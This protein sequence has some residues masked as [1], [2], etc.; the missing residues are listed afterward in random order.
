MI[1]GKTCQKCGA[2]LKYDAIRRV[3]A[4]PFC[5]TPDQKKATLEDVDEA[6]GNGAFSM[7]KRML[8]T[9]KEE[10][11]DAPRLT[12][13]EIRCEIECK[14]IAAHLS[15][16]RKNTEVLEKISG[17]SKWE[18]LSAQLPEERGEFVSDVKKYCKVANGVREAYKMI[19][20][21]KSA[22]RP[23]EYPPYLRPKAPGPA[24]EK[25]EEEIF[26]EE[27]KKREELKS[28]QKI[29]MIVGLSI[30]AML[31]GVVILAFLKGEG[32]AGLA[33][34]LIVG[35]TFA[36]LF[37]M[38]YMSSSRSDHEKTK[39][40]KYAGTT[41]ISDTMQRKCE[42]TIQKGESVLENLYP[43]I[44]QAEKMIEF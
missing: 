16:N 43:K 32:G 2:N 23:A 44:A 25:T 15:K 12:L 9:L 30:A 5:G 37:S 39:V 18:E 24:P 31:L 14:S 35:P 7:A 41:A 42:E 29:E 33:L 21:S 13:R 1:Q 20:D 11:P 19:G 36:G 38:N 3:I 17:L 26:A 27:A 4:C 22:G 8:A 10:T 40:V 6:I 28:A 34:A